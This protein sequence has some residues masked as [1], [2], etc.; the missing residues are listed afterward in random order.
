MDATTSTLTDTDGRLTTYEFNAARQ[1]TSITDPLGHVASKTFDTHDNQLTN[2]NGLG[3]TTTAVYNP[4]NTLSTITAPVAGATGTGTRVSH[5]YPT[6]TPGEAWLEFHPQSTTDAEN[7]L[8]Q[9][10]YDTV[11]G[12][13]YEIITPN[14]VGGTPKKQYQGDAAATTC[15]GL[16]GQLCKNIDGKGNTTSITYNTA[17]YPATITRPAPLGAITN[18]FD[19]AGR[20]ATSTD[21]KGQTATYA[22]DGNDRLLQTRF[23]ATCVAA[24]CVTYTYDANGNL[25]TRVDGS[26]TTTHTYDSQNRPT[27]KTI[28]GATTSLTYDPA[29]NVTSFTD[30]TGTVNY[31]YDD[32]DRL[33]ALAEPGGSCPATPAFPN[34][35]KC[36]GFTYDNND[37]RTE[38]KYPNG[39]KNTTLYDHTGRP[40]S[41]TATNTAATILAQRAY[42]YNVTAATGR[43]GV[44]RKTM[45]TET[46]ATTTYGYDTMHRLLSAVTGAVT[47]SWTYDNNGNRLT[48][49]KTGT[50]TVH[51]AYNAADQLCWTGA[52][53][54]TCAAPPVGAATYI[55]DGNGNATKAGT[56]TITW[57]VFN[58]MTSISSGTTTN[59]TYA[60][61]SNDER[62]TS[63]ATSFLNGSLGITEQTTAG[64]DTSFIRDP[65]GTLISMRN[66]AGACFYY[67]TDALGSVI[68]LTDSAQAVVASYTYDSW[69]VTTQ[70]GTQA[71]ANPWRY[72]GGYRDD[73]TGYTKFG[74]RYYAPLLGRFNQPDPSAQEANRYLYTAANPTNNTDPTGYFYIQLGWTLCFFGCAGGSFG[75]DAANGFYVG[76]TAGVGFRGEA[77]IGID[78]SPLGEAG[79]ADSIAAECSNIPFAG[80]TIGVALP[81]PIGSYVGGA[82]GLGG[83]CSLMFTSY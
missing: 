11:L 39:V 34:S 9:F 78:V 35:T 60:G 64:A 70:T 33:T 26:G 32:A 61:Q 67:T 46:N 15:G 52:L 50:A 59:F 65:D 53:A 56:P 42:T 6:A 41:I 40:T 75:W 8:T 5:T 31:R 18:T 36:T 21:G 37:R 82:V 57:S 79:G 29:S 20:V 51:S 74:A 68:A 80:K 47:E 77:S 1:I 66:S 71:A 76:S 30:P 45:T 38:T 72:A 22:Y 7:K 4:N 13:P 62:L 23:G 73:A 24:T 44:L 27:S 48:A 28:G 69:G 81:N 17:R 55:F 12:L 16:P 2:V 3:K 43:D 83:G 14:G 10:T 63:G 19:A 58:Q 49:A 54:G 25:T